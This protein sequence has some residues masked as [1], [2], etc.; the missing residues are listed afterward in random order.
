[1][2][3]PSVC[4]STPR[5]ASSDARP[6][7]RTTAVTSSRDVASESAVVTSSN[8][9]ARS[10]I[11]SSSS[12]LDS[13]M[14]RACRNASV[15]AMI[16]PVSTRK[17]MMSRTEVEPATLSDPVGERKKKSMRM[18][19]R[20]VARAVGPRPPRQAAIAMAGTKNMKLGAFHS[21]LSSAV[22]ANARSVTAAASTYSIMSRAT[23][24]PRPLD[25]AVDGFGPV[26]ALISAFHRR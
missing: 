9:D 12:A 11:P 15:V 10:A 1:M 16:V 5:A 25:S 22:A 2:R 21:R 13:A 24:W 4:S 20:P 17:A 18:S 8:F 3:S 6:L 26:L 19:E 7:P 23:G 14:P